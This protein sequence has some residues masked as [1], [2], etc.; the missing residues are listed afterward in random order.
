MLGVAVALGATG[1][2]D[3]MP[4][5][6]AEGEVAGPVTKARV[7][8]FAREVQLGA[9][10]LPEATVLPPEKEDIEEDEGFWDR[11]GACVG[12][13]IHPPT[14][15]PFTTPRYYYAEGDEKALFTSQIE[16]APTPYEAKALVRLLRSDRG[17][18]CFQRLAPHSVES[19]ASDDV[20]IHDVR[21]SRLSTP[22]PSTPDA[23][24][25][26]IDTTEVKGE[27]ERRVFIDEIGFAL[28][29]TQ[30]NLVAAGTPTPVNQDVE[31]SLMLSLYV[32]AL[33]VGF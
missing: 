24:G 29:P 8:A 9:S 17:F 25:L 1:C 14:I 2:G 13:H 12:L 22:L 18:R 5:P 21:V 33:Q 32:R 11:L 16:A 28:G 19:S 31:A 27:Q 7:A 6:Q 3:G 26:R 30:V 20:E 15:G 4:S 23:F 10:D